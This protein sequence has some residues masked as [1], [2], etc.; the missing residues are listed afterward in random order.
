MVP[1]IAVAGVDARL[2]IA[3]LGGLVVTY[4]VL[5][6]ITNLEKFKI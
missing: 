6:S 3:V 5:V 4:S 1:L 2:T